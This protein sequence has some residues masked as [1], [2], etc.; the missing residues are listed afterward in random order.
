MVGGI[1]STDFGDHLVVIRM[2]SNSKHGSITKMLFSGFR[3]ILL[4]IKDEK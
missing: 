1:I 2:Y 4:E 3:S